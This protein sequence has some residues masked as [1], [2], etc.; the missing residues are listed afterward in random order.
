M[1]SFNLYRLGRFL[2]SIF[3]PATAIIGFSC[4]LTFIFILYQPT[5]GPGAKQR[6]G[7]QAWDIISDVP[8]P[9]DNIDLG[10]PTMGNP[11]SGGEIS[12]PGIGQ[13]DSGV[14][15]WNVSSP[16]N[17]NDQFDPTSLPLDVWDPLMPH[18]TGFSELYVTNCWIDPFFA[19]FATTD[20]CAP[21]STKEQDAMKGKWVQVGRNLNV[22]GFSFHLL[23]YRRTRRLD[24][25]LI[26]ALRV[27][28][29]GDIPFDPSSSAEI[30]STWR[31]VDHAVSPRGQKLFLWYRADKN[32]QEMSNAEKGQL[33]TEIDVT[34]GDDNP[35][36]GFERLER[37][38]AP[39]VEITKMEAVWLTI[40]RG[41]KSPPRA[42]PLHFSH[43]GSY[44]ILQVADLHYSVSAGVCRDTPLSPCVGSDNITNSL[45]SH[46]LDVEKPDL[47]VFSGDQL[48]GQGTSWDVKSVLAKFAQSVTERGIPWAA[49]FGNHDDEDGESREHQIRYMQNLPYSLV[50]P[51]PRDIHGVGNYLLKVWSADASKTQLLTLYFLDSGAYAKSWFEFSG[52]GHSTEYDWIHSDQINWFLEE[53]ARIS[54]IERPFTPDGVKDMGGIWKRQFVEQVTPNTHRLAKPNAMMFFHIPLEESFSAADVDPRTGKPLDFGE[55]LEGNGNS[56]KQDG[57][58][59]K[60]LL[61]AMESDHTARGTAR[62]VKVVSNG[63]DHITDKCRRIKGIWNC[64]GGGGSYSGYGKTSFDRRFRV[65]DISDYGETIRTYKR[66][67]H[68][69]IVDDMTLV[70]KGAPP[71]YEGT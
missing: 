46:I 36:Y 57:F 45:L 21:S 1:A 30:S 12:D 68:D 44:K 25:P 43:D 28:P 11:V 19:P 4:L 17:M 48:N 65:Y 5:P 52:I 51:G 70:G 3:A 15:W 64:F 13:V 6:L 56:K 53:S 67:E 59:H 39:R 8:L 7:W 35:W 69:E 54:P 14:D 29:E 18:D 20:F 62:E 58:F 23:Y 33:I 10:T 24:V 34:Y 2:R 32:L 40:R 49:V 42:P 66:T 71:P 41:V 63:H 16:D 9:S 22:Q 26:T 38:V 37:P 27:L 47:I 55:Q 61:Q 50:E 31:K 60:A